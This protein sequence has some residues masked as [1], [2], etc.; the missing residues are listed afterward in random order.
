[1]YYEY[2]MR[3]RNCFKLGELSEPL[4]I[5]CNVMGGGSNNDV[6]ET[7]PKVHMR[8]GLVK[9]YVIGE[10]SELWRVPS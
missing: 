1:M 2:L 5:R 3:R 10:T 7:P 4:D 9:Y 6:L 8:A